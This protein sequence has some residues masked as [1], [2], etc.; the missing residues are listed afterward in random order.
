MQIANFSKNKSNLQKIQEKS[1]QQIRLLK[2]L[3]RLKK[4]V[5]ILEQQ[6]FLIFQVILL[7]TLIKIR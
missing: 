1:K 7:K 3:V 4:D 5:V 2:K 6:K